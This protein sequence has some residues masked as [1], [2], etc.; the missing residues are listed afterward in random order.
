MPAS[1]FA[2]VAEPFALGLAAAL[3]V[4][5]RVVPIGSLDRPCLSVAVCALTSLLVTGA[6][7]A[8]F[9]ALPIR[10]AMLLTAIAV[11]SLVLHVALREPLSAWDLLVLAPVCGL[12]YFV[13]MIAAHGPR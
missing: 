10:A 7:G 1:W 5:S 3:F 4:L 9:P 11:V 8:F 2:V 12:C 13:Y 6:L